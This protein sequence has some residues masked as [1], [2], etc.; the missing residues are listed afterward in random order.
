MIEN[1]LYNTIISNPIYLCVVVVLS[2]LL[3]YS[4]LK[5]FIKLLVL[6]LAA[7]IIYICFL[8]FTDDDQTVQDGNTVLDS[9]DKGTDIIKDK[10]ENK[11]DGSNDE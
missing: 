6:V 8:Y 4:A 1:S 5:K 3:I 11:L 10:I 9:I 2:I 7:I